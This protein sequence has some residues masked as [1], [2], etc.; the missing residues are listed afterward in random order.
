MST[1]HASPTLHAPAHHT[2]P[3]PTHHTPPAPALH[4]PRVSAH[5]SAPPR[6]GT[7]QTAHHSHAT[8]HT[9]PSD[10][11]APYRDLLLRVR[12]EREQLG[13]IVDHPF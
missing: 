2:A 1:H 13:Q 6:P 4:A 10:P 5:D 8:H 11:D 12:E 3:A 9:R 7:T